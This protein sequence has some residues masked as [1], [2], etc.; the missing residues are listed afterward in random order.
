MRKK[1]IKVGMV[2]LLFVLSV[3]GIFAAN[4][5]YS[6]YCDSDGNSFWYHNLTSTI[7]TACTPGY[8]YVVGG[9]TYATCADCTPVCS[10][11]W[12]AW[13][14]CTANCGSSG[15]QTR[16]DGC[17]S[18]ESQACNRF[19]CP[20]CG[21]ANTESYEKT[22][23]IYEEGV[24]DN[25]CAPDNIMSN[26]LDHSGETDAGGTAWTWDCNRNGL[27]ESCK[28]YKEGLCESDATS[29][30]PLPY[31]TND[32]ACRFG[33]FNSVKLVT[34]ERKDGSQGDILKWKCGT[35]ELADRHIGDFFSPN[36]AN[37]N[38]VATDYYGPKAGGK[39]CKIDANFKYTC[40]KTGV[41]D[42]NNKCGQ[43]VPVVMTAYRELVTGFTGKKESISLDKY[44][45][46]TGEYCT[47]T[48]KCAACGTRDTD[49]GIYQETN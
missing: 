48:V 4:L 43:E 7:S 10:P 33:S 46:E 5:D 3:N 26:W 1:I 40:V 20:E 16:S 9:I 35:G 18:S 13:G 36:I 12:G 41:A 6:T 39:D 28:A 22:T 15:V 2:G 45:A 17:G 38:L 42:C 37:G 19:P 24:L 49:G 32:D 23:E 25:R 8:A 21:A 47:G 34:G 11:S 29:P 14:D 30:S 44:F 31:N 27:A